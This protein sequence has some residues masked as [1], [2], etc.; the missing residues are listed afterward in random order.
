[1]WPQS[2]PL[3]TISLRGPKKATGWGGRVGGRVG[4]VGGY[5]RGQWDEKWRWER[6][7]EREE[8]GGIRVAGGKRVDKGGERDEREVGGRA[9]EGMTR[10]S[11]R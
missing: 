5:E 9:W 4:G 1:M 10:T 11:G 3:T 8:S 7:R 2:L 6:G